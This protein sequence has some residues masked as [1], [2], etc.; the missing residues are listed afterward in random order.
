MYMQKRIHKYTVTYLVY[1]WGKT[2]QMA[3]SSIRDFQSLT[4]ERSSTF[5][6]NVLL[7]N[8]EYCGAKL[9]VPESKSIN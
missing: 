6:F 2:T 1:Y 9:Q 4:Y 8:L 3:W 5:Q 7:L